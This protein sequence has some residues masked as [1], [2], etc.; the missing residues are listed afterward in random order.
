[1][2]VMML[3]AGPCQA[4]AI[5]R[6]ENEMGHEVV[7]VDYYPNAP[8]KAFSTFKSDASTFDTEACLEVAGRYNVDGVMTTGTDQPVYTAAAVS[9]ALGLRFFFN[10]EKALDA[11]DKRRMKTIMASGGVPTLPHAFIGK[12]FKD[13]EIAHLKAPYVIKPL[14]SQGQRGVFRLDSVEAVRSS[15]METLSYSRQSEVLIENYYPNDEITVSGWVVDGRAK[16]LTVVDR[17][18]MER[19]IHIGICTAHQFPSRHMF[20]RE[21]EIRELTDI[22]TRI[23]G[24]RNGPIYYQMLV[25]SEGI[26]INEIACRIGGA[27]EDMTIP[28]LTG[29]DI[30]KLQ[31]DFI[32]GSPI[33]YEKL[34]NHDAWKI[35]EHL[36]AQLFFALPGRICGQTPQEELLQIEGVFKA[37]Y[38]LQDGERLGS[39]ENATQRAG[40][41]LAKGMDRDALKASVDEVYERL[42]FFDESG[43]NMIIKGPFL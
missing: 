4:N 5:N 7:A 42:K 16:I 22:T 11:T 32:L 31:T 40:Y 18:V 33:S 6:L 43:K 37:G 25:G 14:D 28:E 20:S 1:M 26:M 35:K 23:F 21:K 34:L 39:I 13:S 10:P 27:Y 38:H 17:I 2:R 36:S 12:R 30:L 9:E 15:I 41:F 29:V 8:G 24:I 19:G 3:G